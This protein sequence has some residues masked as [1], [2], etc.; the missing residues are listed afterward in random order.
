MLTAV[1][2]SDWPGAIKVMTDFRSFP[3]QP[4]DQLIRLRLIAY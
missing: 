1:W 3:G 2:I 4:R